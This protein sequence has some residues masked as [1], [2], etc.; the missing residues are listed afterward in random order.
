M[1]LGSVPMLI[2]PGQAQVQHIEIQQQQQQHLTQDEQNLFFDDLVN[3]VQESSSNCPPLVASGCQF[4][5]A[6]FET[7]SEN[8]FLDESESGFPDMSLMDHGFINIIP[9]QV[10]A[11]NDYN[12]D[13]FFNIQSVQL[14][15]DPLLS[16]ATDEPMA[17]DFDDLFIPLVLR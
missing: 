4:D 17:S 9:E 13:E 8:V 11:I 6:Q 7:I 1:H 2:T 12:V 14:N 15:G 10:V 5:A 16:N 3:F